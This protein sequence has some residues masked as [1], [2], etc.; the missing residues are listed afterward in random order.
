MGTGLLLRYLD[1]YGC[2]GRGAW[3]TGR[4]GVGTELMLS[5]PSL[6]EEA[7]SLTKRVLLFL[8]GSLREQHIFLNCLSRRGCLFKKFF[9]S[10]R[11]PF[12][13]SHKGTMSANCGPVW[14]I[15]RYLYAYQITFATKK[16][17]C[18]IYK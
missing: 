9:S 13:T 5:S 10:D 7:S 8:N 17:Q 18:L 14:K 2:A 12:C 11:M 6:K 15:S 4:S 1:L 3:P 16:M